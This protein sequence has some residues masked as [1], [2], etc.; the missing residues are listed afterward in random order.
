[1]YNGLTKTHPPILSASLHCVACSS[2][3]Y[4]GILYAHIPANAVLEKNSAHPYTGSV[5]SG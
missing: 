5:Y 2:G 3:Y 4:V 1:M